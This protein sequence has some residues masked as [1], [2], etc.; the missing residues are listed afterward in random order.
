MTL[1]HSPNIVRDGLVFHIDFANPKCYPGSGTTVQN[2]LPNGSNGEFIDSPTYSSN[3]NGYLS[4]VTNDGIRFPEDNSLDTQTPTVSVWIKTNALSQNGFWFEK[5]TV[6]TQYSLFQ[7]GGSIRWRQN[8]GGITNLSATTSSYI[9]TSSWANV[10]GSYSPGNRRIYINGISV[11]SDTFSGALATT[12]GGTSVGVYGGYSGGRG[13]W[14]NGD[15]GVVSVYD[16]QLSDE[17]VLQNFNALR[18]RYGI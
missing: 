12:D 6:N 5:G 8:S 1:S 7:E 15:I 17:E 13:Y 10:I 18:G 4:F 9:P 16:K 2:L 14:Y 3:N 11:A